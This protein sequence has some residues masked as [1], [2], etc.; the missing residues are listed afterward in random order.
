MAGAAEDPPL[1]GA[2]A[3]FSGGFSTAGAWPKAVAAVN[4]KPIHSVIT[5]II[6]LLS[7]VAVFNSK[8]SGFSP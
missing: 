5:R 4:A 3:G 7:V 2:V 1:A 8:I 6:D